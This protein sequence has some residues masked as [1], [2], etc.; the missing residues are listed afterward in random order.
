MKQT[1]DIDWTRQNLMQYKKKTLNNAD[2]MQD[3]PNF[4]F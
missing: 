3:I 1:P 2:K 4:V